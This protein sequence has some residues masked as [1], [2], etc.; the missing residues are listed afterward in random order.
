VLKKT[1]DLDFSGN[2]IANET[3]HNQR[4]DIQIDE[5]VE[6]QDL[7]TT[8]WWD[9]LEN[10]CR[11]T[12]KGHDLRSSKPILEIDIKARRS[13]SSHRTVGKFHSPYPFHP[14]TTAFC[15]WTIIKSS[16]GM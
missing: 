2:V 7:P 1:S 15:K 5:K 11:M 6:G 9:P 3:T 16:N 12:D 13:H 14:R 4:I 10:L 8:S